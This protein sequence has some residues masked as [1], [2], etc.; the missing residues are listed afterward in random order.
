LGCQLFHQTRIFGQLCD[1]DVF[2]RIGLVA[3]GIGMSDPRRSYLQ[4]LFERKDEVTDAVNSNNGS[5]LLAVIRQVLKRWR[6]NVRAANRDPL[7]IEHTLGLT[8]E[9]RGCKE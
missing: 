9:E 3:A 6:K 2:P 1:I 5:E 7:A 4:Q 8:P